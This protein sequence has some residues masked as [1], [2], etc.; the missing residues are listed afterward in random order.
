MDIQEIGCWVDWIDLAQERNKWPAAV[1]TVMNL[2]V[3]HKTDN[4]W[5]CVCSLRYPAC[6]AHASYCH[7]WPARLY[8]ISPHYL[9]NGTIFEKKKTCYWTQNVCL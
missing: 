3:P 2:R 6:N 9:I 1:N 4:L 5:V 8:S 7:L